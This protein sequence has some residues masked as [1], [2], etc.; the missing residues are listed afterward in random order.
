MRLQIE[1][2]RMMRPPGCIFGSATGH[3]ERAVDVDVDDAAE[4]LLDLRVR[5]GQRGDALEPAL[6]TSTSIRPI[7]ARAARTAAASVMSQDRG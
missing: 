3:Q 6:L 4:G 2:V 1:A 5:V 7:D